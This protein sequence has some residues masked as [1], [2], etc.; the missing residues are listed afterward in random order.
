VLGQRGHVAWNFWA[1][2]ILCPCCWS[3]FYF[4]CLHLVR[5]LDLFSALW[6]FAWWSICV[7]RRYLIQLWCYASAICCCRCWNMCFRLSPF[8]AC[9]GLFFKRVVPELECLFFVVNGEKLKNMFPRILCTPLFDYFGFYNFHCNICS[10]AST[11]PCITNP[12][13]TSYNTCMKSEGSLDNVF[14]SADQ[15]VYGHYTVLKN[16][17]L[18]YFRRS[19]AVFFHW[20]KDCQSF[21]LVHRCLLV[22]LPDLHLV[23][24]LNLS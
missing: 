7:Q 19:D 17:F 11:E 22:F 8:H 14:D 6:E 10:C 2:A 15:L 9:V 1:R 12:W 18:L 4:P 5:C 20:W 21:C 13:W 24:Y 16:S 3:L 23:S